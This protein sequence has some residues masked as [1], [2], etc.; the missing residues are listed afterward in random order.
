MDTVDV[1][2]IG[3]GAVGLAVARAFGRAGHETLVVEREDAF[4]TGSSS[5]NSEVIHAGIY[6]P[7]GSTKA[8]LCVAGRDL[9]YEFAELHGVA[10]RRCGKLLVANGENDQI[11]L[12]AIAQRATACGVTDLQRLDAAA[13]CELEP[14]LR[15]TS[16]YLSPS[17]GIIDS[18]GY[19]LALIADIDAAGGM[20]AYSAPVQ[21]W[22]AEP[23]GVVLEIGG[24]DPIAVK[25][26][27]VVNAAGHGA[28]P[29]VARLAGYP[30][31][32]PVA[33]HFA[34]GSYFSLQG[35]TPFSR[36]IYPAPK[37]ASLGVHATIDLAG[38]IRFGPD[39]EWVSNEYDLAV[40]PGRAAL[41]YEAI[42][43]YWP[44]L[45]DGALMPDYAGMRSKIHGP[46]RPMPDFRIEATA[47]HGVAGLINLLGIESPGLTASLAIAD[48]VLRLGQD[49]RVKA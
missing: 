48:E 39:I 11:Q 25:A 2:V 16:A 35:R 40:D 22:H 30:A 23:G 14:E 10:H 33:Q 49:C 28:P 42:R 1:V 27:L 20:I 4:G 37:A 3:A 21:G 18:H 45:P 5:R 36:L 9:L 24:R 41:F 6:Y 29:L 31:D 34:K 17:T 38:R 26:G 43:S 32:R 7:V 47:D 15:C 19:M 8:R 44:A 46:D 12:D 13:A